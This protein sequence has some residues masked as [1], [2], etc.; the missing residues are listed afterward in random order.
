MTLEQELA[1]AVIAN[2]IFYT[3]TGDRHCTHCKAE[4]WEDMFEAR[5]RN[6]SHSDNCIVLKAKQLLGEV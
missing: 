2:H 4:N 5:S 3:Q 6:V 1:K